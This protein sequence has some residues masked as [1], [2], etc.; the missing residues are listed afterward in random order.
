LESEIEV[1]F[2]DDWEEFA[3]IVRGQVKAWEAVRPK[4][5]VRKKGKEEECQVNTS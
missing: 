2:E 5:K 3:E 4:P 1:D